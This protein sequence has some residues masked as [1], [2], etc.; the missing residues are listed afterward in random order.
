LARSFP[1]LQCCYCFS[2]HLHLQNNRTI[3]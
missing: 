2:Y 1:V 3:S